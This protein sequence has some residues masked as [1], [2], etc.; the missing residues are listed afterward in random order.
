MID[1]TFIC[2]DMHDSCIDFTAKYIININIPSPLL[3]QPVFFHLSQQLDIAIPVSV[4]VHVIIIYI[5]IVR[6][7]VG[8]SVGPCEY[9]SEEK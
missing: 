3:I 6:V 1:I 9:S 7:Y 2:F 8:M 5:G 4:S